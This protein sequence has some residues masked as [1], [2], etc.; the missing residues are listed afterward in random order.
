[1][2]KIQIQPRNSLF[3]KFNNYT[4][5]YW[6]DFKTKA[7]FYFDG[8]QIY[9][10]YGL[11]KD[12]KNSKVWI[13]LDLH[14]DQLVQETIKLGYTYDHNKL[15][16]RRYN[17]DPKVPVYETVEDL[18]KDIQEHQKHNQEVLQKYKE[19]YEKKKETIEKEQKTLRDI[20]K[21]LS[22]TH[23]EYLI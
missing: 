5:M 3:G 11:S 15:M 6:T 9:K 8:F 16:V 10:I 2:K 14:P 19:S 17:T 18:R 22:E 12:V 20:D 1:M 23:P 7:N 4:P 13:T 21:T